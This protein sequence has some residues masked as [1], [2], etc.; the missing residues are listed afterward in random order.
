MIRKLRKSKRGSLRDL[1]VV[2]VI[3]LFFAIVMLIG[4]VFMSNINDQVQTMSVFDTVP[5]AR[6]A[7]TSLTDVYTGPIDAGFMFLTIGAAIA[8]LVLAALV[9]IHPI[10]I[11]FYIIGLTVVII[12]SAIL[13]NIYQEIAANPNVSAYAADF[14]FIPLVMNSL[15][16]VIG[17]FGTLLAIV[18]YKTWSVNQQ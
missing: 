18:S 10:F 12:M 17:I 11:I 9:R 1:L 3:L 4:Y 6:A 14:T 5:N 2:G 7:T 16:F 15:P 13:S 8:T